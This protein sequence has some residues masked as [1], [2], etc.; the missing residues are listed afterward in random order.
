MRARPWVERTFPVAT[1]HR[2]RKVGVWLGVVLTAA[3]VLWT[4]LTTLSSWIARG[5][6]SPQRRD[7][8]W[9]LAGLLVTFAAG[10]FDDYRPARTRGLVRQL[11]MLARGRVTSGVVKLVAI[12]AASFLSVWML[13][14]REFRL[15]LGVPLVAGSANLWN[16]LDVVPGRAL[17]WFLPAAV[18]LG[19][20]AA[21]T[22]YDTLAA[23][24]V[25]AAIP[26]LVLDLREHAMLGDAGANVLGFVIGLGLFTRLATPWLAAVLA[27]ILLLHVLAETVTLSRLIEAVP[28]LRWFDHLGRVRDGSVHDSGLDG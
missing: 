18:G 26:A 10:L 25:G 11:A 17:K 12:A 7:L 16:L 20:A 8:L 28:P 5:G 2:G 27:A 6:L 23:A 22:G 9:M 24:A 19:V 13:G 4:G 1:N 14:G 3:V 21:G 15:A